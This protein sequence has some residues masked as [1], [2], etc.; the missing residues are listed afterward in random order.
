MTSIQKRIEDLRKLIRNYDAAYY[1][2][3]E[4]LVSDYDYDRLYHELEKLE[5]AH[6]EFDSPD[7]P[8]KRI[9]NDLTK[10]FP[11]VR[12]ATPMMSIDNTYSADEVRE[13]VARCE[14]LLPGE[15]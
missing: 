2:R 7:S 13:W 6:P 9:G 14:K 10:E 3:G 12:H 15:K 4:S 5:Q 8:G 1:G 11:K